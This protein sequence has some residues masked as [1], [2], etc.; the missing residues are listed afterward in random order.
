V[1]YIFVKS[2]KIG[3]LISHIFRITN[4]RL[5]FFLKTSIYIQIVIRWASIHRLSICII[6]LPTTD[7]L[8]IFQTTHTQ[9]TA[10]HAMSATNDPSAA[11]AATAAACAACQAA[12]EAIQATGEIPLPLFPIPW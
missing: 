1:R 6:E 8:L 10:G 12:R 3:P 2:I 7:P 9:P 11:A 5:L 4:H